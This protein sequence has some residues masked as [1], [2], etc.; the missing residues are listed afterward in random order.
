MLNVGN[1]GHYVIRI[2]TIRMRLYILMYFISHAHL[3]PL[4]ITHVLPVHF[5]LNPRHIEYEL[6]VKKKKKKK[7][8]KEKQSGPSC[9]KLTRS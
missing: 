4:T 5:I 1:L 9:S 8:K 6:R 7:E 2:C 3:V